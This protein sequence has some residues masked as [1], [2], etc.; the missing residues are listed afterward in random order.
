MH[1]FISGGNIIKEI[2]ILE[3]SEESNAVE[4]IANGLLFFRKKWNLGEFFICNPLRG[5]VL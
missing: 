3:F 4:N 2:P 5:E 1:S